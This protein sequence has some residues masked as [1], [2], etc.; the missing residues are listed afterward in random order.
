MGIMEEP[1]SWSTG[2]HKSNSNYNT[3][4]AAAAALN[5][6]TVIMN[7]AGIVITGK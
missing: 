3:L 7:N 6:L 4:R 2:I 5:F 1:I